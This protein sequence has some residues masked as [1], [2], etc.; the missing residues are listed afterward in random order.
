MLVHYAIP[1]TMVYSTSYRDGGQT[2]IGLQ[3]WSKNSCW[4]TTI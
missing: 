1:T 3:A 2:G 4:H